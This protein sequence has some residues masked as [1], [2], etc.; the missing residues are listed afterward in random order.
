[1]NFQRFSFTGHY[2][3]S[4]FIINYHMYQRSVIH[5]LILYMIKNIKYID[6]VIN[7]CMELIIVEEV[8]F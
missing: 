6:E 4:S 8:N 5:F 1:M 7:M 3:K 2:T